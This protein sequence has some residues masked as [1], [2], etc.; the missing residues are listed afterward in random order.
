[1]STSLGELYISSEYYMPETR[2]ERLD[3][4]FQGLQ[5]VSLI[6]G[7]DPPTLGAPFKGKLS[8]SSIARTLFDEASRLRAE[9]LDEAKNAR[10]EA[11]AGRLDGYFSVTCKD[12]LVE[13]EARCQDE[14]G[15]RSGAYRGGTR[16]RWRRA[17]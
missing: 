15:R 7:D 12:C 4:L 13:L 3:K 9:E 5:A 2:A 14:L 11:L 8:E 6:L 16:T 10:C 17:T 1:M